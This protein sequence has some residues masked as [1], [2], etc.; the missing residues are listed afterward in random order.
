MIS[1]Y[2]FTEENYYIKESATRDPHAHI[3]F[4]NHLLSVF[5]MKGNVLGIWGAKK[6]KPQ[7]NVKLTCQ[8]LHVNDK[9]ARVPQCATT[10]AGE[11]VR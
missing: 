9:C 11:N 8:F 2:S 1:N 10:D 5:F 6:R 3:Q 4:N 7:A